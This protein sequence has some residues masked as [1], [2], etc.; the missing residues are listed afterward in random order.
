MKAHQDYRF[1]RVLISGRLRTRA[2]LH[3][4]SGEEVKVDHGDGEQETSY[5][6]I[7][8]DVD[9]RPY[10]PASTLRGLIRGLLAGTP[11]EQ[12]RLG[13]TA[14]RALDPTLPEEARDIGSAGAMRLY[15]AR[16]CEVQR[17]V[18]ADSRGPDM[19]ADPPAVRI[20]H[21]TA[22]NAITRTAGDHLLF[23]EATVPAGAR[24][25]CHFEL[26]RVDDADLSAFCAALRALGQAPG[27]GAGRS[28][29]QGGLAWEPGEEQIRVLTRSRL[30]GW[31]LS[32]EPISVWFEPKFVTGAVAT[33]GIEDD[34]GGL[35]LTARIRP[36]APLLVSPERR[37]A[38]DGTAQMHCRRQGDRTDIPAASLK[39]M[40]RAQ[41]RRILLTRLEAGWPDAVDR[42]RIAVA[43]ALT[44]E[45]FGSKRAMG[46]LHVGPAV[47]ACTERDLHPQFFN[48][49]DRFTGGVS[50]GKLYNVIAVMPRE[51]EWTLVLQPA[52]ILCTQMRWALALLLYLL[53]DGIEGDL[54]IGWGRARGFG[55]FRL[56]LDAP[57]GRPYDDWDDLL[58]RLAAGTLPVSATEIGSWLDAL[59]VTLAERMSDQGGTTE[60]GSPAAT[61]SGADHGPPRGGHGEARS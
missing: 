10:I 3:V 33:S 6:G 27:I 43:D 14:R 11:D 47:G 35:T 53:R 50:D 26:D 21:R 2:P 22:L 56:A 44:G 17:D 40:L 57:D 36:T 13:G 12:L 46:R 7:C 5:G 38:G 31:L 24:F 9:G 41:C 23:A 30:V 18:A 37:K 4:G 42:G 39:G 29:L 60:D 61:D 32:E 48:A 19:G 1:E 51:L 25:N 15:D 28:R 54:S 45:I 49:I 59:D 16:W 52:L 20:E 34:D 55:G 58:A 8:L